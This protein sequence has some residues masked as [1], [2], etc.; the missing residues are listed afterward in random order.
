M[1]LFLS[2]SG[3]RFYDF[4]HTNNAFMQA[5]RRRA[6]R[7]RHIN[8][9]VHASTLVCYV[10]CV[11]LSKRQ[12]FIALLSKVPKSFI[13][14]RISWRPRRWR[15]RWLLTFMTHLPLPS[16]AC[17]AAELFSL[18]ALPS[19]APGRPVHAATLALASW[20]CHPDT[21]AT[22]CISAATINL[23]QNSYIMAANT[24]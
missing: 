9:Q 10:L 20:T 16:D 2:P 12:Q 19:V 8:D 23:S 18:L 15:W 24:N 3:N 5:R 14:V 17:L 7:Y 22:N 1:F 21:R 13:A 4:S 6:H 11:V